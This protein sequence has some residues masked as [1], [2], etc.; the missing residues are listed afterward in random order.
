P[1]FVVRKGNDFRRVEF[2]AR[3]VP[4][5]GY[6]TYSLKPG[7][8]ASPASGEKVTT[9]ESKYYRI[10]IDPGS[11]AVKSIYDQELKKELV[12]TKSPYR[13]GQYLYVSGGDKEPNSLLQYRV[14][15]PKP[16]LQIHGAKNG[17]LL[18]SE[19]TAYGWRALLES[20][21]ENTPK[22]T[23]EIRLFDSEKKI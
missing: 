3:D 22:I 13:F 19:K 8:N 20:S 14:V 16:E 10:E 2:V 11:G 12:D 21:A 15:S 17:K 9:L 6:K 18:A 5:V 1:Y 7:P 4:A 23:T